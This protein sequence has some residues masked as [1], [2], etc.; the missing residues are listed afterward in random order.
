VAQCSTETAGARANTISEYYKKEPLNAVRSGIYTMIKASG[1][2][3]G[4]ADKVV[5]ELVRFGLNFLGGHAAALFWV[6]SHALQ[7]TLIEKENRIEKDHVM[8]TARLSHDYISHYPMVQADD[9]LNLSY[10]LKWRP[11]ISCLSTIH[12]ARANNDIYIQFLS[13]FGMSDE[14]TFLLSTEMEPVAVLS[15][16][17]SGHATFQETPVDYEALHRYVEFNFGFHPWVAMVKRQHLLRDIHGLTPKEIEV[18]TL[19]EEGASNAD[20][21]ATL[22]IALSTVKT[23]VIHILDK[24]RA[25]SRNQLSALARRLGSE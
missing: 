5:D 3:P 8:A 21:S 19:I 9:P 10:L 6:G 25:G 23:H 11:S 2:H 17:K 24:T 15:I 4:A 20:I 12:G 18:F 1:I 22:N 14:L 16:F 13:R 7:N